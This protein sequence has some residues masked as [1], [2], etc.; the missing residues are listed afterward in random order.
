MIDTRHTANVHR[1]TG[2]CTSLIAMPADNTRKGKP[3]I[4]AREIAQQRELR[5]QLDPAK[6]AIA[7]MV[8]ADGYHL[9]VWLPASE[10]PG[11]NEIAEIGRIGFYIIVHDTEL[12]ELPLNVGD[13]FPIT[14]DPA[15]WL[16]F[17]LSEAIR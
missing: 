10:L 2:Y 11:F 14:F 6:C 3:V 8:K 9:A 15:T 13:D 16:Q 5:K 1:A 7:S 12:G 4:I 17:D